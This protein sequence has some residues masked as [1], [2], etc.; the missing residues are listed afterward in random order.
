MYPFPQKCTGYS[1]FIYSSA[2]ADCMT[3]VHSVVLGQSLTFQAAW[4]WKST[5]VAKIQPGSPRAASSTKGLWLVLCSR[6]DIDDV[7]RHELTR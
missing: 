4:F 7:I 6:S 3:Q 2:P 5:R 1:A